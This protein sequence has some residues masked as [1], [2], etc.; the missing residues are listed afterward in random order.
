MCVLKYVSNDYN[1]TQRGR[2]MALNERILKLKKEREFV[3]GV[4][5]MSGVLRVLRRYCE[6]RQAES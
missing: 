4:G 3:H 5:R 1:E 2:E 6:V